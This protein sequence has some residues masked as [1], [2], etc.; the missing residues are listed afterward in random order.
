[1]I[2]DEHKAL[3]QAYQKEPILK[4]GMDA[5]TKKSSFTD[6]RSLLGARFPTLVEYCG[7]VAT[8]FLGTS[9]VE[10]VFSIL[11]LEKDMFQ[12]VL[13][14]GLCKPS[15]ISW[16]NNFYNYWIKSVQYAYRLY[17][18]SLARLK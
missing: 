11:R 9:T 5:L 14:D 1:M 10:I 18:P 8:V 6:G 4:Q 2:A 15:N 3:I 7:I 12:Q 17:K 13:Y 16:L